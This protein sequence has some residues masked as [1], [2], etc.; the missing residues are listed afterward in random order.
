[1]LSNRNNMNSIFEIQCDEFIKPIPDFFK[2]Y[3]LLYSEETKLCTFDAYKLKIS[4][5]TQSIIDSST[6]NSYN[7]IYALLEP[8]SKNI[9]SICYNSTDPSNDSFETT[10]HSIVK[11]LNYSIRK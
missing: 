10:F 7:I 1:M 3:K 2:N 4:Y 8:D 6:N 11:H 9:Y 5:D